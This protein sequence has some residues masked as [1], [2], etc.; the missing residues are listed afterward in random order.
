[1]CMS[2]PS[3]SSMPERQSAQMPAGDARTRLSDRETRR[4]GYA[5]AM[6][7]PASNAA[8]TTNITG[9]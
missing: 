6:I 5:A 4:R 7:A 1:M 2:T 3:V 8:A 9:V